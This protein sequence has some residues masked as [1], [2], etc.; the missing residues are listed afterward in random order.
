MLR[1][2]LLGVHLERLTQRQA[3]GH[4]LFEHGLQLLAARGVEVDQRPGLVVGARRR[5]LAGGPDD[6]RV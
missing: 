1:P 3:G 6:G 4:P 5:G 2:R